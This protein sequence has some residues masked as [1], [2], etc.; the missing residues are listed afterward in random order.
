[1]ES[2]DSLACAHLLAWSVVCPQIKVCP[3][4]CSWVLVPVLEM[5]ASS[6]HAHSWHPTPYGTQLPCQKS[7]E[8][9]RLEQD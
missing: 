9:R 2:T 4:H 8:N 5:V 7:W 1:M 6:L 3:L